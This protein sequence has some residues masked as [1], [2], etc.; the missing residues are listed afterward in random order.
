MQKKKNFLL[1]F[2]FNFS[3]VQNYKRHTFCKP[4]IAKWANLHSTCPLCRKKIKST[5]FEKDLIPS[6]II[7]DMLVSCPN[8]GCKWQ[9]KLDNLNSHLKTC[10]FEI[11]N[12]SECS[13]K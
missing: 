8:T 4:C 1:I 10:S 6:L 2:I 13:S 7:D 12:K 11:D 3:I 5:E 9:D